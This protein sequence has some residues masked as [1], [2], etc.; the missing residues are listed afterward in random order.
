M[1]YE[2]FL[3]KI[4]IAGI[5]RKDWNG[6]YPELVRKHWTTGGRTG[7]GWD[8]DNDESTYSPRQAEPE[9]EVNEVDEIL[10]LFYPNINFLQYKLLVKELVTVSE[11]YCPDYYGNDEY[12]SEKRL[13]LE[14]F[15][16]YL[17]DRGWIS[18][19]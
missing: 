19:Y 18:G 14:E 9:P 12:Y 8:R 10:G 3:E 2:E 16:G 4:E 7:G 1:T 15:Y 13:S 6:N 5:I 17:V 11:E